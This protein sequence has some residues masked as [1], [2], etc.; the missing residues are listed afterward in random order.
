MPKVYVFGRWWRWV[1]ERMAHHN[2]HRPLLARL[3]STAAWRSS[4]ALIRRWLRIGPD[5]HSGPGA[6][7]M[8]GCSNSRSW[9]EGRSSTFFRMHWARKSWYCG[10]QLRCD[11]GGSSRT[12]RISSSRTP[13]CW[14]KAVRGGVPS[15]ISIH[16]TPRA[17]ISELACVGRPRIASGDI[18]RGEPTIFFFFGLPFSSSSIASCSGANWCETPKSASL[19][20]PFSITRMLPPFTSRW[21]IPEA[22]M[23]AR[24]L[25]EQA[26]MYATCPSVSCSCEC[27]QNSDTDPTSHR[28]ISSHN[29]PTG[30]SMLGFWMMHP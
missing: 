28:S 23:Y 13:Y 7:M 16:V 14:P 21:T 9:A 19:I 17:Q 4:S 6:L 15:L 2:G 12:M 5:I 8:K 10:D 26:I 18:H 20:A 25:R 3:F 24:A 1:A 11:T 22:C 27:D 30:S 29:F